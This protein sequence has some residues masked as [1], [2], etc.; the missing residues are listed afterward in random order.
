MGGAMLG[1]QIEG[2]GQ[3]QQQCS[4]QTY[5]EYQTV[6]YMVRYEYNGKQ[7]SAQFPSDPG[8]YVRL[9]VVPVNGR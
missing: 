3:P 2:Q 1:D 7:Y 9:Q 5:T 8:P 6:G 4:V